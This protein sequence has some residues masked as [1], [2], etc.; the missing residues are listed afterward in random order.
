MDLMRASLRQEFEQ[1]D[2]QVLL[3][4]EKDVRLSAATPD[5]KGAAAVARET[6][7][8][9]I[10]FLSDIRRWETDSR[11]L[12][13]V[14]VELKMVRAS[15]GVLLWERRIQRAVPTPSATNPGQSYADAVKTVVDEIFE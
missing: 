9:G 10:I 11:Q 8:T 3:P 2:F 7:L 4:E 12:V 5:V 14:W 13:R 15:D 6:G 1:R